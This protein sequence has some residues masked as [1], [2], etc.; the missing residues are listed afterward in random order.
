MGFENF[1][2]CNDN[3]MP[4][5]VVTD[6]DKAM[7]AAIEK[8]LPASQHCLCIWHLERNAQSNLNEKVALNDFIRCMVSY[9]S[10]E[11]FG[12]MW[13]IMIEKHGLHNHEW[14]RV[15][16]RVNELKLT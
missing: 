7:R 2:R 16:K 1:D 3:K 10:K 4:M 9:V 11:E 6:G 12:D 8:V 5:S 13:S 14:I 15:Q